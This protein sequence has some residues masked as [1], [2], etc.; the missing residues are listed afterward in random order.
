MIKLI[1]SDLD[2]TLLKRFKGISKVNE[3]TLLAAQKAGVKIALAT[4]R[5]YDS[6]KQ[7]AQMLKLE[8]YN[9]FMICNNGQRLLDL[10]TKEEVVNGLIGIDEARKA[11]RFAKEHK[12]QL[13]MDG[14]AGLAFYSPEGLRI[15]RDIYLFMLKLLP[16]FR[17]ILGRIHIFNLFGFLK[18]QQVKIIESEEDITNAYDKIG[19]S[20]LK[21]HLDGA[22]E[23]LEKLFNQKLE[24]MRVSDNWLDVAPKGITKVIGIYQIM[25]KYNIQSDEVLCLGDSEND[26][27]MLAAFE[28]SVA[29]GNASDQIKAVARFTTETNDEDGV[30]A[31]I[32]R[33]IPNLEQNKGN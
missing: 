4:G 25:A 14:D 17:F 1:V 10:K 11:F 2:G 24:L 16:N 7:F 15:Y 23:E 30:A 22:K 6:T 28:H 3:Q 19:Y 8:D 5:G 18:N 29:M 13:V 27:T 33:F 9:G 26:I 21:D 31:A 32:R 20:H 12:L